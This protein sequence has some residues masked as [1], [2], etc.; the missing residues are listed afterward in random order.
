[1]LQWIRNRYWSDCYLFFST[2]SQQFLRMFGPFSQ[3]SLFWLVFIHWIF[4]FPKL[5]NYGACIYYYV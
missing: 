2:K 3:S 1:M 5:F 4:I